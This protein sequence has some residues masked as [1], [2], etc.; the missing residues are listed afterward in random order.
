M[1]RT[2]TCRCN[3]SGPFAA[4]FAPDPLS[5]CC[6]INQTHLF[7]GRAENALPRFFFNSFSESQSFGLGLALFSCLGG[8]L[9]KVAI[10]FPEVSATRRLSMSSAQNRIQDADLQSVV[11]F[12]A[13]LIPSRFPLRR[14]IAPVGYTRYAD[15]GQSPKV[16]LFYHSAP[17][18]TAGYGSPANSLAIQSD[19]ENFRS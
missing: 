5:C 6:E 2:P 15:S 17:I 19:E 14:F 18:C 16:V 12:I 3:K 11:G 4:A 8:T 7:R 10:V 13:L 1:A 9:W